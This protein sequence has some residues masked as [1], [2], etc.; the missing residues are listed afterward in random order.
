VYRRQIFLGSGPRSTSKADSLVAVSPLS[1]KCEDHLTSHTPIGLHGLLV[2]SNRRTLRRLLVTAN[3]LSSP[4]LVTLMKE[5]LSSSETSVLTRATRRNIPDDSILPNHRRENL[6]SYKNGS[7][8]T[9][10]FRTRLRKGEERLREHC[11]DRYVSN[12]FQLALV[13]L[14]GCDVT[15]VVAG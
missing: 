7:F 13:H 2:T 11:G 10:G 5:E 3:V 14:A 12:A 1:I 9:R 6:K 8:W 4:I 15:A